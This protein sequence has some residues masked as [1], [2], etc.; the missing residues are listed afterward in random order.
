MAA[1]GAAGL[2]GAAKACGLPAMAGFLAGARLERAAAGAATLGAAL[3]AGGAERR[4][5]LLPCA[6]DNLNTA[7]VPTRSCACDFRLLAAAAILA[8]GTS[9]VAADKIKIRRGVVAVQAQQPVKRPGVQV[10]AAADEDAL[11]P[12]RRDPVLGTVEFAEV[13][14]D[15][16]IMS[17]KSAAPPGTPAT[18]ER[19]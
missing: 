6:G 8:F 16:R 2:A 17:R 3:C 5:P 1:G 15:S 18:Q 4:K 13:F 14:Q 19:P 7:T 10:Q 12:V 11:E 9:A